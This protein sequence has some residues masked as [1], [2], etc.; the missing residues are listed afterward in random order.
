M[1]MGLL[2][3]LVYL[4]SMSHSSVKLIVMAVLVVVSVVIVSCSVSNFELLG[5]VWFDFMSAA[6]VCLTIYISF[7]MFMESCNV[8][9]KKQMMVGLTILCAVLINSFS[10]SNFFFF[11]FFFESVLIPTLFL[12]LVW[13]YQPERVQAGTYMVIYTSLGSFP[14]LFAISMMVAKGGSDNMQA[15][16]L[17]VDRELCAFFWFYMLGFLVKLPM[18]PFHLWLPKA[19]VEAPVVGSMILAGV[20]LKLGGY[21]ML[22]YMML[23][24]VNMTSFVY[25]GLM[26][27]SL[28]GGLLTSLMC[29][30]QVDLKSLIAY[31]S[32]GHMSLVI[33]GVMS[34]KM[35]GW[36]GSLIMMLGHGLCSSGLFLLVNLFYKQSGSRS[37]VFN[38]GGLMLFP[39]LAMFCFLLSAGNMAAPPSLNFVGEVLLFM[40]SV[41]TSGW[42]VLVVGLMSFMSACYS[43]FF[44]GVCC[45]GKNSEIRV[46]DVNYSNFFNLFL[47]WFPLNFL[48]LFL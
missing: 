42:L 23:I 41:A 7:L 36:M 43:L 27:V 34:A 17:F 47:H 19:H 1:F 5:M 8:A 33:L 16:S 15:M 2:L 39:G 35:V 45:H 4:L 32:V 12:I 29:L 10:L 25:S 37:I 38:K 30:R 20:L 22:R 48:F 46:S 24:V 9:R 13:G 31:S 28:V 40:T 3:V 18:F 6:M 14:F 26:S 21:G 44:Y 11:F